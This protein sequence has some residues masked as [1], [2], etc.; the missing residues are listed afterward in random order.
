M[1]KKHIEEIKGKENVKLKTYMYTIRSILCCKWI[2]ANLTQPPM[3]IFDLLEEIPG[4]TTFND[5]V[6]G[7]I[8]KK[9]KYPEHYRA[10]RSEVIESYINQNIYELQDNMPKNPE[11]P[12]FEVFDNVFRFILTK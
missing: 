1:A 10:R 7:F 5:S 2:V 11:K 3:N 8:E 9:K 12:D 6:T 4:D